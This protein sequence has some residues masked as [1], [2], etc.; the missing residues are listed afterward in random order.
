MT[1]EIS[2]AA[3]VKWYVHQQANVTYKLRHN[4][5]TN[6]GYKNP[7]QTYTYTPLLP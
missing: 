2:H 4:R 7:T 3:S 5:C 6:E 1:L